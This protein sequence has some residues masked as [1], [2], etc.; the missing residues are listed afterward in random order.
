MSNSGDNRAGSRWALASGKHDTGPNCPGLGQGELAGA[1]RSWKCN[2]TTGARLPPDW[3]W[4]TTGPQKHGPPSAAPIL[5]HLVAT[6]PV[7]KGNTASPLSL[8]GREGKGPPQAQARFS[9]DSHLSPLL[10]SYAHV[11]LVF[12]TAADFQ[13]CNQW[14]FFF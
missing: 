9:Q 10:T 6:L 1:G 5:C 14:D 13:P 11:Q 12:L 7:Q 8:L 3:G 2:P 4:E